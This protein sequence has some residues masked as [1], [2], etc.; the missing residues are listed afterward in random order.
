[1]SELKNLKVSAEVHEALRARA[2]RM[3]LKI[4]RL[5]DALLGTMLNKS[6]VAIHASLAQRAAKVD[7]AANAAAVETKPPP[8]ADTSQE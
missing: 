2:E 6:D 8:P 4:N 7:A 5:A 3:G 1:M